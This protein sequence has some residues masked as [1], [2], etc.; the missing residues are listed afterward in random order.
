MSSRPRC[1][2]RGSSVRRL[3][4]AGALRMPWPCP[5]GVVAVAAVWTGSPQAV[6]WP[7][8]A[9]LLVSAV[10]RTIGPQV[11]PALG[12]PLARF[13]VERVGSRLVP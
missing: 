4:G 8:A 5:H 2:R 12:E 11:A 3:D 10:W 9:T 1:G 7:S 13:S 6:Q